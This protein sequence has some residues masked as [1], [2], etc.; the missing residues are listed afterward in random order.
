MQNLSGPVRQLDEQEAALVAAFVGGL[1]S[2]MRRAWWGWRHA[3]CRRAAAE[4]TEAAA[5][6]AAEF[7]CGGQQAQQPRPPQHEP[8]CSDSHYYQQ[9]V[10]EDALAGVHFYVHTGQE[11]WFLVR[12]CAALAAALAP[13]APT[14]Q[15]GP[16]TRAPDH[17]DAHSKHN[18]EPGGSNGP[19]ALRD[20]PA[21]QQQGYAG[22]RQLGYAA[23][24]SAGGTSPAE[25]GAGVQRLLQ[26]LP[27][28]LGYRVVVPPGAGGSPCRG[29]QA[30]GVPELRHVSALE[31]ECER[32]VARWHGT[33]LAAAAAVRWAPEQQLG[34]QQE[35][36]QQQPQWEG[37]QLADQQQQ[38]WE[39][40]DAVGGWG[41]VFDWK[42]ACG[43]GGGVGGVQG[44]GGAGALGLG[45][46][47]PGAGSFRQLQVEAPA[48]EQQGPLPLKRPWAGQHHHN[49]R[50]HHQQ[51][52]GQRQYRTVRVQVGPDVGSQWLQPSVLRTAWG[53]GVEGGVGGP[54]HAAV[55][56]QLH[57]ALAA[58]A[59][60]VR[61]V[62][63]RLVRLQG[64]CGAG[65]GK[66]GGAGDRETQAGAK[67]AGEETGAWVVKLGRLVDELAAVARGAEAGVQDVNVSCVLLA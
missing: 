23:A 26:L 62:E 65:D 38:E 45:A 16:T 17:T 40:Q 42:L 6:A 33:G 24:A 56:R 53:E 37:Q 61:W 3:Q 20:L 9:L 59:Q 35:Q 44:Q 47:G 31:E 13:A 63:E 22:G 14:A 8:G 55:C 67:E 2:A 18:P 60:A 54:Q 4:A 7:G 15:G 1:S 41:E 50:N 29:R 11:A 43:G 5:A 51:Q 30:E 57:S 58:Q 36:Q 66:V 46:A 32:Y 21:G 12:R 48:G 39:G 10:L 64:G 52:R 49:H 34:R 27:E 28:V 25:T 19:G